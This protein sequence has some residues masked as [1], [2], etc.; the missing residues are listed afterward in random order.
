MPPEAVHMRYVGD[1]LG[2]RSVTIGGGR[3]PSGST[4]TLAAYLHS[5]STPNDGAGEREPPRGG[6]NPSPTALER[7]GSWPSA[8]AAGVAVRRT[9]RQ[10]PAPPWP[11]RRPSPRQN[12]MG[13]RRTAPPDA[14]VFAAPRLAARRRR[15]DTALD[16][17][18]NRTARHKLACGF[19][20]PGALLRTN[21]EAGL[22]R[23]PLVSAIRVVPAAWGLPLWLSDEMVA[24]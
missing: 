21:S 13:P 2:C 16:H 10:P 18:A 9:W 15:R 19:R 22:L 7:A 5:P 8:R 1:T 12:E 14:G 6:P 20:R 24:Q 3:F 17:P 23:A 11:P 4:R